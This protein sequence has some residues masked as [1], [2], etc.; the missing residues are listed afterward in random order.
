MKENPPTALVL[1]R[2]R[3]HIVALDGPDR[4]PPAGKIGYWT[5]GVRSVS[6]VLS[7]AGRRLFIDFEGDVFR[8]NVLP[9]LI[10]DG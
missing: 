5:D 7:G 1:Q 2:G 8:T 4:G 9:Y 3:G 10:P 6:A